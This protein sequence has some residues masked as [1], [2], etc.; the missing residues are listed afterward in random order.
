MGYTVDPDI[1]RGAAAVLPPAA[2]MIMYEVMTQHV[3]KKQE[4]ECAQVS[5]TQTA[6]LTLHSAAAVTTA[7]R[8]TG[9]QRMTHIPYNP[10]AIVNIINGPS[11]NHK[12]NHESSAERRRLWFEFLEEKKSKV[13]VIF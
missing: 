1:E 8:G 11:L 7:V 2:Y 3:Q 5:S 4:P 12:I 6:I 9:P 13:C 10:Y